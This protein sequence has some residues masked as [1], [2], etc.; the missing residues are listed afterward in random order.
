M[1]VARFSAP[2]LVIGYTRVGAE[3][4]NRL[5]LQSTQPLG[6]HLIVL[7]GENT[8]GDLCISDETQWICISSS[9]R[10]RAD[11]MLTPKELARVEL[12]E[13]AFR[14]GWD[15]AQTGGVDRGQDPAYTGEEMA[16]WRRCWNRGVEAFES[17]K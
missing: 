16:L 7:D 2:W 6:L 13:R 1:F 17:Q 9:E 12:I 4:Y 5:R 11:R 8:Y 10:K 3:E 15:H 14:A